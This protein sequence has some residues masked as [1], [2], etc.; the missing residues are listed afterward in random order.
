M[1]TRSVLVMAGGTG[2]HIFP[3]LAV[4]EC[5]RN[6]GW[7]VAWMGNPTG[8]E[9]RLVPAKGFAFEGVKFSGLRGKGMLTKVLMPFRLA[10]AM[11]QS[12]KILRRLKPS[13]VLGMGGYI[14]FPGGL[15]SYLM[16]R[17]L[18]LHEANSVAG[19]ANRV[20]ARFA[21]RVLT[22]FP[23]TLKEAQWV[24]NPIRESFES[25]SD[26]RARYGK[27]QGPLHLLIVGG[28]LG[29]TALNT[30]VPEALALLPADR[31]PNVLHQTGEQHLE[32][33]TKTYQQLGVNGEL[34]P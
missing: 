2:G 14:T 5:L 10:R 30:V 15:V 12:W 6:Q 23:K 22:G 11:M 21:T 32:T 31:R 9:Y 29:A 4:A 24:G 27:R 33:V 17:P 26:C 18:V 34:K 19:S 3:G 20:L 25:L 7:T 28:S 1:A 13:V 16:G 8:M